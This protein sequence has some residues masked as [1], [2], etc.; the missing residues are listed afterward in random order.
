MVSLPLITNR[1]S[2]FPL[3]PLG[4]CGPKSG[5]AMSRTGALSAV[6]PALVEV[7]VVV[8]VVELFTSPPEVDEELTVE[9][10][11][12]A[13]AVATADPPPLEKPVEFAPPPQ[14]ARPTSMG[15]RAECGRMKA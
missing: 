15:S 9:L 1:K 12:S 8:V 7:V 6:E 2:I 4:C 3:H 11:E 13:V 14:A 5:V 10:V